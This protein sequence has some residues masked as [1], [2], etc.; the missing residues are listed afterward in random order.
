VLI[1][2]TLDCIEHVTLDCIEHVTWL[3]TGSDGCQLSDDSGDDADDD[4]LVLF[5][6]SSFIVHVI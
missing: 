3:W 5:N 6:V 4:V 1:Q 2:L